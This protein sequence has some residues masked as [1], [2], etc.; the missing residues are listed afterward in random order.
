M[1][2]IFFLNRESNYFTK[3][4][5]ALSTYFCESCSFMKGFLVIKNLYRTALLHRIACLLQNSVRGVASNWHEFAQ[6][7]QRK[8]LERAPKSRPGREV[9]NL[10]QCRLV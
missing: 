2:D 4:I 1:I 3:K 8:E 9:A 6:G 7:K 10:Q 5:V